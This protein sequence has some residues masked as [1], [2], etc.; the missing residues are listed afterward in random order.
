[1]SATLPGAMPTSLGMLQ[2]PDF[3]QY[4]V[5]IA[6]TSGLEN[7]TPTVP[8]QYDS[9]FVCVLTTYSNTLEVG[10]AAN[11]YVSIN[12]GGV[13]Q[14]SDGSTN[15][16]LQNI[17]VPINA[18]FGSAREPFVWPKPHAFRANGAIVVNITGAGATMAGQTIRLVFGGYKVP[19]NMAPGQNF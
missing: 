11:G 9:H 8:I 16:S 19:T 6:F 2:E 17:Q 10:V 13:V 3:F 7:F 12:G 1:M 18:L 5:N 15:R 4:A 14:L